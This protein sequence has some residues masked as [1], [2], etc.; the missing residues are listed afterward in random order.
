MPLSLSRRFTLGGIVLA[1]T[2]PILFL[3]LDYQPS[4]SVHAGATSAT[5]KLS[6]VMVLLTVLAA[7][8]AARRDGIRPLRAGLPVWWTT[9]ALLVWIV[10]AV[11]YPLASTRAYPWHTHIVTAGEFGEYM[12]LAPAVVLILRRR[13][14]ALLAAGVLVAWTF[15]ATAVGFV[16]WA[17]WS[18]LHGW[19]QG[20]RQPSF[21]GPHDFASLSAMTLGLGLVALLWGVT[22]SRLRVGAWLALGTGV[23][24]F[25]LGGASAGIVG[26]VPA[27][28][29][30]AAVAAKR[31]LVSRRALVA[32]ALATAVASVGVVA[33]RA[34]DFTQF[35]RFAGVQKKES[36]T[37][38][39]IQTYSQRTL[40]AYIG[41][42][43]WE[44]HPLVGV[45]WQ[46]SSDPSA[47]VRELP[48]AHKRF[49]HVAAIA[50]PSTNHRYGVQI[51]YIQALADLGVVGFALLIAVFAAGIA[52]GLRRALRA[53]PPIAFAAALGLFWLVLS[54]G[55]WTA[56]GFVAGI[57]L[58]AVT[59]LAAGTACLS[60]VS[61]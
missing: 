50:F 8:A 7:A 1:A 11:F 55:L 41:L 19:G 57:P 10:A 28:I 58:D 16:Q 48:A 42:R 12:L 35:L 51:L 46:G 27:A 21:L 44:H 26:L 38:T 56:V 14:D 43:I 49:P 36:S 37:T 39:N 15:V 13:A 2:L 22:D 45:G 52:V 3:H 59:W 61:A 5:V 53:P 33:L 60:E 32:A 24:G 54:L 25:I 4:F 31:K 6:D 17:G 29:V 23:V 40:L 9:G 34:G 18:G 47:F 20:H 30:V